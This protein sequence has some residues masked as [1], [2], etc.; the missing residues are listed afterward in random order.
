MQPSTLLAHPAT[1][2]TTNR[3]QAVLTQLGQRVMLGVD[4][5][6]LFQ[7][8]SIRHKSG[9]PSSAGTADRLCQPVAAP[10]RWPIDAIGNPYGRNAGAN[11]WLDRRY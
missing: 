6:T 5:P 4:C 1:Q 7:E 11:R 9:K 3:H 2:P 10:V 8:L